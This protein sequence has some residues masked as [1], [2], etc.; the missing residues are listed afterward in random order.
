MSSLSQAAAEGLD[1]RLAAAGVDLTADTCVH[2]SYRQP[3]PGAV[4][5]TNA[6]KIA[7]LTA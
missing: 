3:P 6:L 4:L 5:A 7:Y 1:R 2:I